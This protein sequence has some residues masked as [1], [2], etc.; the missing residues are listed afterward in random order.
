MSVLLHSSASGK[1]C[2]SLLLV[3]VAGAVGVT[4]RTSAGVG[5]L[6]L[7][8]APPIGTATLFAQQTAATG[9]AHLSSAL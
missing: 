1:A 5:S 7:A 9:L 4:P 3:G 6:S 2:I 8:S